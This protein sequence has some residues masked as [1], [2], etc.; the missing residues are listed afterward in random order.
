LS[1]TANLSL[2]GGTG[3]GGVVTVY[4]APCSRG[5]FNFNVGDAVILTNDTSKLDAIGI[6][7]TV[8]S[9][10][11]AIG[12][13]TGMSLSK[14]G[15][16]SEMFTDFW[17]SAAGGGYGAHIYAAASPFANSTLNSIIN[18]A[19]NDICIVLEDEVHGGVA[20]EW[21]FADYNG[22]GVYNWVPLAP[23]N[24]GSSRDFYAKPIQTGEIGD[25]QV[26]E[27]K[28]SFPVPSGGED[29]FWTFVVRNTADLDAW[30]D[31]D[32]ANNYYAVLVAPQT[33]S[34]YSASIVSASPGKYIKTSNCHTRFIGGAITG[35]ENNSHSYQ[36]PTLAFT[37]VPYG[38]Q[39]D[40]VYTDFSAL[41]S[42]ITLKDI[43]IK[44]LITPA[45]TT[46]I[47]SVTGVKDVNNATAD[48]TAYSPVRESLKSDVSTN[49]IGSIENVI[50]LIYNQSQ[51]AAYTAARTF[52][53]FYNCGN[54]NNCSSLTKRY[55][56][57]SDQT[58]YR[59][60]YHC[61]HLVNCKAA[62]CGL[63]ISYVTSNM[64]AGGT[65]NTVGFLS[66]EN[67]YRCGVRIVTYM[68]STSMVINGFESC[69]CLYGCTGYIGFTNDSGDVYA[70]VSNVY[71]SCSQLDMC[72]GRIYAAS[73][74]VTST[75]SG[76]RSCSYVRS[77]TVAGAYNNL[78]FGYG[79][80]GCNGLDHCKTASIGS[81]SDYIKT[82]KYTSSCLST[83]DS[84]VTAANAGGDTA[85]NFFNT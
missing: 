62:T 44:I 22:D 7:Q 28:L 45:F 36:R 34:S 52:Y 18:P 54:L 19:A 38:I 80:I 61:R 4:T 6:V 65:K 1:D 78:G 10:G 5:G 70:F 13:I 42:I 77:C 74:G 3:T 73:G 64:G 43:S 15:A 32:P 46:G 56:S 11:A 30:C 33:S 84:G 24:T 12:Q 21:I 39:D 66:C 16:F 71:L 63:T 83:Q 72:S 68:D 26:T 23:Y 75:V 9:V 50:V 60:F 20:W 67:L 14:A 27:S 53:G 35:S 17:G 55:F 51:E 37:D 79:F 40:T 69:S 31:G 41:G 29:P 2:T 76:F 85:A 82:G 59:M 47:T 81:S 48:I 8:S 57:N 58:T 25:G 49:C